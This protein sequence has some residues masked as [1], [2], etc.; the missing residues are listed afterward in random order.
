MQ[1]NQPVKSNFNAEDIGQI[2]VGAFALSVPIAFSEEA[3]RLSASLPA[4][5]LVL[6]VVL[7]LA[8]I[9]LFAYQ[10]VFQANI[11]KR[12]R[13]FLL[14]VIAAYILTLLVVSIVLLALDKL[15]LITDP[16]LALKRIILIAM[17]ASMGA[18]I[19]DSFDKE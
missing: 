3:W 9:T 19:V 5:N 11:V 13:A 14:R 8:F 4:L 18:I 17:P 10:S 6:V 2:A 1:N 12:R 16:I 15:P 7:S